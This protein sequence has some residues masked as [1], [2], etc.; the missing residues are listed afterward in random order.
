MKKMEKMPKILLRNHSLYSL[1]MKPTRV[2]M[3]QM[4]GCLLEVQ[5][6]HKNRRPNGL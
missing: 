6:V 4:G 1:L 3:T 2:I 5:N